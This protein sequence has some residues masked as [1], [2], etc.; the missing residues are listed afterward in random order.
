MVWNSWRATAWHISNLL[1]LR[2]AVMED[3][4]FEFYQYSEMNPGM[5]GGK[6]ECYLAAL[7]SPQHYLTL[8][9]VFFQS[10]R[11]PRPEVY[12]SLHEAVRGH[13]E[14]SPGIFIQASVSLDGHMSAPYLG[15]WPQWYRSTNTLLETPKL[16]GLLLF[17][18]VP[19]YLPFRWKE[20]SA[21]GF[22]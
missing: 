9:N 16:F 12:G 18:T 3:F 6:R 19:G 13:Q 1:F 17:K 22:M 21:N 5:L 15:F 8:D 4:W 14:H 20:W 7:E 2:D 10:P 11:Y